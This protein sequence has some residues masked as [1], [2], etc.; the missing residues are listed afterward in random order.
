M[1]GYVYGLIC[2]S[3]AL[4]ALELIIPESAK[5]RPYVRLV[6]G[7]AMVL[8]VAKPVGQLAASL[9][10]MIYE[11]REYEFDAERYG[12]MS[13]GQLTDA[14][15]SGVKMALKEKFGLESFEVGVAVGEDKRP[16]KIS[17]T[18]MGGDIFRNPYKIEEY[19]AEVFGCECVTLIGG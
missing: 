8:A 17:V 2:A 14:Y 19:V 12:E 7:L 9:P 13:D 15:R 18:L 1:S 6:F 4:G 11:S 3:F 5:T 16:K 10:D